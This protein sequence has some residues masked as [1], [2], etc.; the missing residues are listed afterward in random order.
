MMTIVNE[1]F[2]AGLLASARAVHSTV[3]LIPLR[4]SE[5]QEIGIPKDSN[6]FETVFSGQQNTEQWSF[7]LL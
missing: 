4:H 5:K 2:P 7:G 6:D 3:T 1:M